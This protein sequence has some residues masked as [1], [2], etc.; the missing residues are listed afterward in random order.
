[1]TN[2]LGFPLA[3]ATEILSQEG[4]SVSCL[5]TRSK[6][7]VPDGTDMRVVRQNILNEGH[8]VLI[9][10]VFRTKPNEANA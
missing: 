5:E 2:V 7:G 6:K 4:I 10:A 3:Q 8:A 9:Y 1:M